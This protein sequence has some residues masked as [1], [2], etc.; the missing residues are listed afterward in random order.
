MKKKKY[1]EPSGG[2]LTDRMDTGTEEFNQFQAVLLNRINKQ[3]VPQKRRIALMALKFKMEDYL[4]SEE[5]K[6]PTPA[7]EFLKSYLRILGI[8]QKRFA[9]YVGIQPSNLSKLLKGERPINFE[10]SL[11]LGKIFNNEPMLWMKIQT[12][13]ELIKLSREKRKELRK[14]S[15]EDLIEE[16]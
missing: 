16:N 12:R 6:E 11:I 8:R 1:D 9:E 5:K 15:L 2:V 13:N 4:Q 3:T 7:G 10:M 14:Y